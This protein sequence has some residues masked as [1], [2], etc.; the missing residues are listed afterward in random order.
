MSNE[1]K[2][3]DDKA[4][5]VNVDSEKNLLKTVEGPDVYD[6]IFVSEDD[7][8]DVTV[9]Y[10]KDEQNVM[11]VK[12]YSDD[13]DVTRK[14]K[15]LVVSLKYPSL[16]DFDLIRAKVRLKTKSEE[17]TFQDIIS[18]EIIRFLILVRK[19]STGKPLNEESIYSLNPVIIKGIL[20]GI[21]EVINM[22]G[23][24]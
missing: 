2:A 23:I 3:I 13:F 11:H 10:Y 20:L 24:I 4:T 21:T 14:T 15:K 6:D 1:T 17:Y 16:G 19:W 18:M 12:S 22:D 7:L 9:E 5:G 8:F